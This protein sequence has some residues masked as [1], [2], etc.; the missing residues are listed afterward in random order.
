ML[1]SFLFC[2]HYSNPLPKGSLVALVSPMKMDGKLD[3]KSFNKLL[4]LHV[5]EGT[6]GIVLLGTTGESNVLSFEECLF[7]QGF[8][9][10]FKM[11][12]S[13]EQFYWAIGNAVNVKVV[14]EIA[15]KLLN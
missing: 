10:K 3:M 4:D 9:K 11:P 8:P 13:F 14:K 15:K 2:I 1:F 7:L 12:Q 5:E 6:S